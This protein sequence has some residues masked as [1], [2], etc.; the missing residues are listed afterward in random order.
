MT[1]RNNDTQTLVL[2]K[3]SFQLFAFILNLFG[4]GSN[5][6]IDLSL[7][8]VKA[9][10]KRNGQELVLF[11]ENLMILALESMFSKGFKVPF[12]KQLITIS[13]TQVMMPLFVDLGL[14]INLM[15]EDDFRLEVT[16][17]PGWM[18]TYDASL[19]SLEVEDRNTIGIETVIPFI[20]SRP[21]QA[22]ISREKIA[23]GDNITSILL[24]N[25]ENARTNSDSDSIYQNVVITSDKANWNDN[26][27]RLLEERI[28]Q[29]QSFDTP[30][31]YGENFRYVPDVELDGVEITLQLNGSNVISQKNYIVYRTYLASAEVLQRA[32]MLS[33]KHVRRNTEKLRAQI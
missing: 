25:T 2:R 1:L 16:T 31:I 14:P 10:L 24:L 23:L 17:K 3:K 6:S 5:T 9:V 19:S 33:E 4:A 27:G 15:G 32:Q 20:R 8:D 26:R 22:T 28:R 18:G 12:N 13:A 30:S 11:H 29:F 21:L 7:I